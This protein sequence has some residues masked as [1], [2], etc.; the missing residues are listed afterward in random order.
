MHVKHPN[1]VLIHLGFAVSTIAFGYFYCEF[2]IDLIM[3]LV[4]P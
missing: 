2:V 4:T 3:S 1:P